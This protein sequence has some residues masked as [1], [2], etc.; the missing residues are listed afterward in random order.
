MLYYGIFRNSLYLENIFFYGVWSIE[1]L[2]LPVLNPWSKAYDDL[3]A[4]SKPLVFA[5]DLS[6][7]RNSSSRVG[8][9]IYLISL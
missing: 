4:E 7:G 8:C 3:E 2:G 6:S 1:S 9:S 5:I